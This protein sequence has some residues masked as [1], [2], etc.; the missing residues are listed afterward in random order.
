MPVFCTN[1]EG[2]LLISSGD[3]TYHMGDEG[4]ITVTSTNASDSFRVLI[5]MNTDAVKEQT[6]PDGRALFGNYILENHNLDPVTSTKFYVYSFNPGTVA[7]ITYVGTKERNLNLDANGGSW[8]DGSK[9][10]RQ[11]VQISNLTVTAN[12][13]TRDGYQIKSWNTKPDGSGDDWTARADSVANGQTLYAIWEKDA[14][15]PVRATIDCAARSSGTLCSVVA[16]FADSPMQTREIVATGTNQLAWA[17]SPIK[18][19]RLDASGYNGNVSCVGT[20]NGQC[21]Y[22]SV[23]R[24]VVTPTGYVASTPQTGDPAASVMQRMSY[25]IAL[26]AIVV[27]AGVIVAQ[28]RKTI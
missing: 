24:N 1:A 21:Y 9:I 23:E 14:G 11:T 2:S 5:E 26:M 16:Y 8:S 4:V 18:G 27:A 22:V 28:R 3:E 7:R 19:V 17:G 13:P 12:L 20:G 10:S 6:T 15:D 25:V